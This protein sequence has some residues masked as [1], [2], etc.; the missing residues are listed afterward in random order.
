M[1][2][3]SV[4]LRFRFFSI[5]I[6]TLLSSTI[7]IQADTQDGRLPPDGAVPSSEL[8]Q[9]K[10]PGPRSALL[11]RV[12]NEP[13]FLSFDFRFLTGFIAEIPVHEIRS[14]FNRFFLRV[15]INPIWPKTAKEIHFNRRFRV[16]IPDN[17]DHRGSMRFSGSFAMGEGIY[18]VLW[19]LQDDAGRFCETRW[20]IDARRSGKDR[21]IDLT[22]A[23]GEIAPSLVY[24]FREE[25]PTPPDQ[26]GRMLRV[27]LLVSMDVRGSRRVTVPLA[28][29]APV[30]SILR[31]MT[32]HSELA[33]FSVVA[34]SLDDQQILF[35]QGYEKTIDF[36]ALGKTLE[37]LTPGTVAFKELGKKQ[38]QIFFARLLRQT[39]LNDAAADAFVF[40]GWDL[41]FGKKIDR[42][43]L[44]EL[45]QNT[46]P[47][48]HL[49]PAT[50][51]DWRG[52]LGNS[53]KAL[54]GK[55]YKVRRPRDL[56][57]AI[58]RMIA[59]IATR[60]SCHTGQ[61]D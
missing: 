6:V 35:E 61:K 39:I 57:V 23:P 31:M 2:R 7:C 29:Y 58:E 20:R 1:Q 53:V 52:L 38:E 34:F 49:Y 56:P 48:F 24:L 28:R 21:D 17:Q 18:D 41:N 44:D 27:K 26:T 3:R 5:F 42:R 47:V 19:H 45:R 30:V 11:C 25:S 37:Q 46:T 50:R 60:P 14:P 59:N 36:P 4:T 15:S 51:A 9:E 10:W 43:V 13:P 8:K 54:G 32:R 12:R 22:L 33:E 40:V 55:R 16:N